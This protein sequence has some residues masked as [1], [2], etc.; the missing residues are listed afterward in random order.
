MVPMS[1]PLTGR[2]PKHEWARRACFVRMISM[3]PGSNG[4]S[5][6]VLGDAFM[7]IAPDNADRSGTASIATVVSRRRT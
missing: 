7:T 1:L 5:R 4:S 6:Y 3:S 2:V